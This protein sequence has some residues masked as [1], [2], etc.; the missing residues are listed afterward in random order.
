MGLPTGSSVQGLAGGSHT[1]LAAA[2]ALGL[3]K[4]TGGPLETEHQKDVSLGESL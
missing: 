4:R 2:V 3:T 1:G